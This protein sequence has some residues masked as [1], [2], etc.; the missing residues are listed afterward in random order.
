MIRLFLFILAVLASVGVAYVLLALGAPVLV[1]ELVGG[2]LSALLM[3][4][5]LA[6]NQYEPEDDLHEIDEHEEAP[7]EAWVVAP[8][9]LSITSE[10]VSSG[11]AKQGA[12]GTWFVRV[13]NLKSRCCGF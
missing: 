12:D 11:Q 1:S 5:A 9:R 6:L 7:R 10:M 13:D 8:P 3:A 2:A 4:G